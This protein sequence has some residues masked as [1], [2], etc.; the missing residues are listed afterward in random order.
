M[1]V[2]LKKANLSF[3]LYLF[4]LGLL[5][6]IVAIASLAGRNFVVFTASSLICSFFVMA[7][8]GFLKAARYYEIVLLS[9][10]YKNGNDGRIEFRELRKCMDDEGSL[11]N[12]LWILK[13]EE[14]IEIHE[15][16]EEVGLINDSSIVSL[17]EDIIEN[18][19]LYQD[20]LLRIH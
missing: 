1:S 11:I 14:M 13:S 15:M 3:P 18:S 6:G 20:I 5:F 10:I 19:D 2:S 7:F 4:G 8:F 17:V 16:E 9:Y 12:T